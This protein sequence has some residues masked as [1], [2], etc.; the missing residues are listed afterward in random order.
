MILKASDNQEV[1]AALPVP[2]LTQAEPEEMVTSIAAVEVEVEAAIVPTH[3]TN[4]AAAIPTTLHQQDSTAAE[5]EATSK[6][7]LSP[8]ATTMPTAAAA[9]NM[10]MDNLETRLNKGLE[11]VEVDIE[12]ELLDNKVEGH[13]QHI[14]SIKTIQDTIIKWLQIVETGLLETKMN[15]EKLRNSDIETISF[16]MMSA[17]KIRRVDV[18]SDLEVWMRWLEVDEESDENDV[19]DSEESDSNEDD[20]LMEN[21]HDTETERFADEYDNKNCES[22]ISYY[23]GKDSK[24]KWSKSF[25]KRNELDSL[26]EELEKLRSQPAEPDQELLGEIQN[27]KDE[28]ERL[29]N[30]LQSLRAELD[31]AKQQAGAEDQNLQ[32]EIQKLK[33]ENERLNNELQSL[34]A[35]LDTAK[36]QAGA[37]D[38]NLQAEIQKLKEENERLNNEL[39]SLRAELDTAKQQAGAEDQNLQAEI[40][41]LKEENERLNN[42]LQSLRAELDAA[43]QQAGAEDQNLLADIQ[44]LKEENERL[45]NELDTAKQQTGAQDQNLLDEIEK[46]KGENER[47]KNT[48]QSGFGDDKIYVCIENLGTVYYIYYDPYPESRK[49]LGFMKKVVEVEEKAE[50]M[51]KLESASK[52]AGEKPDLSKEIESLTEQIKQLLSEKEKLENELKDYIEKNKILEDKLKTYE[53]GDDATKALQDELEALKSENQKLKVSKT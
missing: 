40:Q 37:E 4:A 39:Q 38:Q 3:I 2:C 26:K 46:L 33:E 49:F 21:N 45:K 43:K 35:E 42:E 5:D 15:L 53:S 25:P 32:A 6:S 36:Q 29:Q 16:P 13:C 28:N 47:L 8:V 17:L 12:L 52:E 20:Q 24:T 34:R 48:A 11:H 10:R 27:L 22:S 41:K 44:K 31:T 50:Q 9:V 1:I 18:S 14:H 30:E 51:K 7:P 19:F 23:L